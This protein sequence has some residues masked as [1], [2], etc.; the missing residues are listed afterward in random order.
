MEHSPLC[1]EVCASSGA[2]AFGSQSCST[3]LFGGSVKHRSMLFTYDLH[4]SAANKY[5]QV[6]VLCLVAAIPH[7]IASGFA[8]RGVGHASSV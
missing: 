7:E 1:T 3:F 6:S 8:L 2:Q 4:C 5:T